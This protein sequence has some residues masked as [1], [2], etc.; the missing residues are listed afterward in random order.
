MTDLE[1]DHELADRLRRT[2]TA[3]AETVDSTDLGGSPQAD[4]APAGGRWRGPAVLVAVVTLAAGA[5]ATGWVLGRASAPAQVASARTDEIAA[6]GATTTSTV[7]DEVSVAPA[8]ERRSRCRAEFARAG[9]LNA[10]AGIPNATPSG[11]RHDVEFVHPSGDTTI[12]MISSTSLFACTLPDRGGT[13]LDPNVYELDLAAPGSDD[14]TVD[15]IWWT[16]GPGTTG[17]GQVFVAGRAGDGVESV[18]VVLP[19]ETAADVDARS[20]WYAVLV[21]VPADVGIF[22]ER[23][24]WTTSDGAMHDRRADLLDEE[25]PDEACAARPGCVEDEVARLLEEA[26][27]AEYRRAAAVLRDGRVTDTEWDTVRAVYVACLRST[28][29]DIRFENDL[30]ITSGGPLPA[31]GDGGVAVAPP[32]APECDEPYG[33]VAEAHG[34][35]DA[36][37]RL[38][39][40]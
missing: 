24:H 15:A 9:A 10:E 25:T 26:E 34:L 29:V 17:P 33:L 38:T 28:G 19:D 35:L 18:E 7:D 23:M 8:A 4:S 31:D 5:A 30:F 3:V 14:I 2:L 32:E 21:D 27:T 12:L 13:V 6:P 20:G 16:S 40:D 36:E 39:E 11:T 22:E 1:H 37:R